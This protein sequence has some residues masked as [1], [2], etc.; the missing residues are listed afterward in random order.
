MGEARRVMEIRNSDCLEQD[1]SALGPF[2][3]TAF[4]T[5]GWAKEGQLHLKAVWSYILNS[6][7]LRSP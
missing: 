5:A 6:K 4:P 1:S 7:V 2:G 3:L